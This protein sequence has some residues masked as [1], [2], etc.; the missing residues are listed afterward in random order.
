MLLR[1]FNLS[2][3][4]GGCFYLFPRTYF[5]HLHYVNITLKG[6]YVKNKTFAVIGQ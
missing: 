5:Q 4:F 2:S 3:F 6:H 1:M